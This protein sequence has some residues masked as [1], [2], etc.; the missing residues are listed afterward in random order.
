MAIFKNTGVNAA[1]ANLPMVF[2]IAPANAVK[3]INHKYGKV[4]RSKSAASTNLCPCGPS[5]YQ[6]KNQPVPNNAA[7]T[8]DNTTPTSVTIVTKVPSVPATRAMSSRCSSNVLPCLY[9]VNT[10]TNACANAPSA[11]SRRKKL[12]ILFAKKNTSAAAPAPMRFAMTTSRA[13]P[14]T[15]E[16]RVMKLTM[17]PDLASCLDKLTSL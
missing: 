2:K 10:G 6:S 16:I 4:I 5:W 15:R 17:M 1:T 8:G 14:N 11:N 7:T 9:S 12:G 13:K 3:V